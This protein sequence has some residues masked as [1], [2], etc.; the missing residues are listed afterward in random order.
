MSAIP[1]DAIERVRNI[2]AGTV[3]ATVE[4]PSTG[5]S[6]SESQTGEDDEN[7]P[8]KKRRRRRRRRGR[9]KGTDEDGESR[10]FMKLDVIVQQHYKGCARCLH[11]L[12][13][14]MTQPRAERKAEHLSI[15]SVFQHCAMLLARVAIVTLVGNKDG[16]LI[17]M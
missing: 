7:A 1:G 6:E 13:P 10:I 11:Q 15:G 9:R 4:E 5:D 12:V 14:P 16:K 3:P 8:R 17:A 2:I